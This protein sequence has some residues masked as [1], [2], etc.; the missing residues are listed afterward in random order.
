MISN[1]TA[2]DSNGGGMSVSGQ[3]FPIFTRCTIE[4]NSAASTGG[5]AY[6]LGGFPLLT[7]CTIGGNSAV[8]AG[9][10]L[11]CQGSYPLLIGCT[12]SDNTAGKCGGIKSTAS[13]LGLENTT[14]CGNTVDQICGAYEDEGGNFVADDCVDACPG[15]FDGSG[16]V[17]VTDLLAVIGSWGDPYDVTDLLLVISEWGSP[18]P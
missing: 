5:G 14:V 9:G 11:Y 6:C 12:V 18:C 3:S 8:S 1:N 10:G 2:S 4:G 13:S 15:D 17:D 16:T 7:D